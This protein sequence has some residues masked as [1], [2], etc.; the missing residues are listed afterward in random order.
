MRVVDEMSMRNMVSRSGSAQMA[1]HRKRIAEAMAGQPFRD[2][3]LL[4]DLIH[5]SAVFAG[6]MVEIA[7]VSPQTPGATEL[8][9]FLLAQF[10][11]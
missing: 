7:S 8:T 6:L 10:R 5:G 3:S 11:G 9:Q 1:S 4:P 2:R